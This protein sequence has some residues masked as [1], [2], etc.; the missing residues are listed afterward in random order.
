MHP[1]AF[2][3]A[4]LFFRAYI[5]G[6]TERTIVEIGALNVNGSIREVCPVGHNYIGVDLVSGE[7]VDVVLEDPYELP[8]GNQSIDIVLCSSV[9]EHSTLYWL[10]ILE[11]FRVLKP[12]GLFYLNA[13]SNG[14]IHR[15]PLDCWRFYPDAG[16]ALVEWLQRSGYNAM[17]LE[18][19]IGAKIP[20]ARGGGIWNDFVAVFLR[21][22][23]EQ[24]RYKNRIIHYVSDYHCA[25][26]SDAP[27]EFNCKTE[28]LSPDLAEIA[29]LRSEL[30][31]KDAQLA[32]KDAQLAE[33]DAQL[34]ILA[35][36]ISPLVVRSFTILAKVTQFLKR[37]VSAAIEVALY[38][39][40]SIGFRVK[41]A[42]RYLVRGDI[43]GMW[44]RWRALE[45]EIILRK[46]EAN[47]QQSRYG[48]KWCV[49]AT[50]HTLFIAELIARRLRYH[51]WS[52]EILT[53]APPR[54]RHDWYIVVCP[55]MFRTLPPEHKRIAYQMEQSVSPRWFTDEYLAIL[56]NSV[57]VCDYS[58][59]NIGFLAEKG[60][61]YPHVHY[62]PIGA[63]REYKAEDDREVQKT[64]DVVFYGDMNSSPRRRRLLAIL[65]QH[66]NVRVVSEV[67]GHEMKNVIRS[68]RVVINLHYYEDALLEIPRIQECLSLGVPVVSEWSPDIEDYPELSGAVVFFPAGD[69]VAMIDTVR[70]VLGD[71]PRPRGIS[72]AVEGGARRFTF[73]FDR[74]LVALG[75]LPLSAVKGMAIPSLGGFD[76]V[77]L[78]L[79]ET[80]ERRSEIMRKRPR[81]CLI[82]DGIRRTPG[83]I[84]CGLSY[85]LLAR[86]ALIEG[87]R[88]LTV[89]EDD[90]V[91]PAELEEKMSIIRSYLDD[92]QNQWDI[93]SGLIAELHPEVE[94][95]AVHEYRG[96]T[97]ATLNRMVSMVF[98]IYNER[99]LRRLGEWDPDNH[100]AERNTIDRY[101]ESMR[102]LRIIVTYPFLVG[103]DHKL[104]SS[105]WGLL[106]SQYDEAIDKSRQLLYERI[107]NYKLN[108]CTIES[109]RNSNPVNLWAT[110][111]AGRIQ[112]P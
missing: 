111:E 41:N 58:L 13:P 11:I 82:F 100:D 10:L 31:E 104:R 65:E 101:L 85:Q 43:G 92:H 49:M 70:R 64:H 110:F 47:I 107:I 33:T 53:E 106:N 57:A 94:V 39:R 23:G 55:Q 59:K 66:F 79:P 75:Y 46:Q 6:Q 68:A 35:S 112:N 15:H 2:K 28:L 62:V 17:V 80:V 44:A 37:V 93:F 60:I 87:L 32:E 74:C 81:G 24:Y 95:L 4:E 12:E 63:L 42:M 78:S 67:F 5:P 109:T 86:T 50:P 48:R 96:M 61:A 29:R 71:P 51:G 21:H 54:F 1:S 30:A 56:K 90:V 88:T 83:W 14:Y 36:T 98:N 22:E 45:Q 7:G 89:M 3:F 69:A 102:D 26:R 27:E 52:V 76:S 99:V 105:V 108:S 9:F 20:E 8:F 19:F 16:H 73:M 91:L 72:Q 40:E 103:H 77:A 84:G 34:R 97:F 38:D 18:S 25:Y